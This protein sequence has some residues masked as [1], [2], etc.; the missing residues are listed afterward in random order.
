MWSK[1]DMDFAVDACLSACG[2]VCRAAGEYFSVKFPNSILARDDVHINELELLAITLGLKLWAG[3]VQGKRCLV[4]T[5]NTTS[6][7]LLA[8]GYARNKFS[9]QCMREICFVC[10]QNDVMVRGIHIAG[11]RNRLPDY[12][13]RRFLDHRFM[14]R[15]EHATKGLNLREVPVLPVHFDF[16]CPW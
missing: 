12:L 8:S 2:G 1:P 7:I 5:D 3:K 16:S 15:F 4:F 13:S 14:T 6:A 9:Q 11:A 10:A